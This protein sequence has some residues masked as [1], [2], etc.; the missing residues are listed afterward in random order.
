MVALAVI[1]FASNLAAL[2]Y[3]QLTSVKPLD[4]ETE[5]AAQSA[6]KA[7]PLLDKAVDENLYIVGPG[8]VFVIQSYGSGAQPITV[9]VLPEG[10]VA[11][12]Q[13]GV[14]VLGQISLKEAKARIREAVAERVRDKLLDVHLAAV[15]SF[16]VSVTGAVQRP[17]VVVV[18][19]ADRVSEAIQKAGGLQ[20]KGSRRNIRLYLEADT[21][22]ADLA[23]FNSTGAVVANPYLNEGHVV[24]VPVVSDTFDKIEVYGAVNA[25]GVFEYREGDRIT[26]LIALGFGLASDADS[27]SAELIRFGPDG[28]SKSSI[29]VNLTNVVAVP[30][31][32]QDL[33]LNA[34]DRLFV[35]ALAG[36]RSKEQVTLIGEVKYPGVYPIQPGCETL[37]QLITKAGGILDR[38]SLSESEMFRDPR[39]FG[40]ESKASAD[41]LQLSTDKLS[42]FELQY[43]KAT[44]SEKTGKVAVDF[45]R[46]YAEASSELDIPLVDGDVVRI[47]AKSFSV[48]VMGRVVNPGLVPYRESATVDYYIKAAGGYGYKADRGD[49]RLI[50]TNTGAVVKSHGNTR[51]AMGDRIMVPQKKG[52][53]L[54]QTIKDAGFFLANIATIYIVVDQAVN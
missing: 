17:G 42:E 40:S 19:G 51:V 45:E 33:F 4:A 20:R 11:I 46:L 35:R 52:I 2:D 30:G 34:D 8:D 3:P 21:A 6:E 26:D 14:I 54:W 32:S 41:L 18:S 25:P 50:K 43:L 22:V 31:G 5:P 9:Q 23:R 38:A 53:D 36:Y 48:T 1:G 37:K 47:P 7:I 24:F 10:V 15:R 49:I 29:P 16:K 27:N 44:S 12:P 13:V 28:R 39:F